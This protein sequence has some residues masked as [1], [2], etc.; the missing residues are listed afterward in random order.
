MNKL[1][2][3]DLN[4]KYDH[5]FEIHAI[6]CRDIFHKDGIKADVEDLDD[7]LVWIDG[8]GLGYTIQDHCKVF[9]CVN[10]RVGA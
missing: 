5:D 7:A 10:E 9:P 3:I 4:L 1:T 2:V 6:G 8:D